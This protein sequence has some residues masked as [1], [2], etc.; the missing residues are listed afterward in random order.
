VQRILEK[1]TYS[2]DTLLREI[3]DLMVRRPPSNGL[4][5]NSVPSDNRAAQLS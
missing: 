3:R 2:R 1:C 4:L 5:P